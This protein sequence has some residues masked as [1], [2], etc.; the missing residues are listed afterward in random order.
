MKTFENRQ[1]EEVK[2]DPHPRKPPE[3]TISQ[4][5]LGGVS[6]LLNAYFS[7]NTAFF[8]GKDRLLPTF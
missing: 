6:P 1:S 2:V 4:K 3:M 8:I 7:K 5:F